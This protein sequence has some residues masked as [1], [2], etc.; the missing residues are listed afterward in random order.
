MFASIYHVHCSIYMVHCSIYPVFLGKNE[1]A[2]WCI[3][4]DSITRSHA[5]CKAAL[6]TAPRALIPDC[7]CARY[8]YVWFCIA[9][10]TSPGGWCRTSGA[11]PAAPPAPAMTSPARASTWMVRMPA[12]AARR[13]QRNFGGRREAL[14]ALKFFLYGPVPHFLKPLGHAANRNEMCRGRLPSLER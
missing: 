3:T 1:C 8:Q 5:D 4:R 6:T 11:G 7:V 9:G 10:S 13:K 14:T 12:F 2:K